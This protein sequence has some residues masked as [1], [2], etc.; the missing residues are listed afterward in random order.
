MS[1]ITPC[2]F[3]VLLLGSNESTSLEVCR[4]L[5]RAGH[6]VTILRIT[7]QKTAADHSRFCKESLYLGSPDAGISEYLSKLRDLLKLRRFDYLIPIDSLGCELTYFDYQAI[8]SLIS[9]VG[10]NPDSYAG[11][12]NRFEAL[13]LAESVGLVKPKTVLIKQGD[14]LNNQQLPCIVRPV[15]SVAIIDDEPQ[16]FS[17]RKVNSAEQLDAK[18]R[19][20]L[21]RSDVLLQEPV[22]GHVV[23]INFCAVNGKVLAASATLQL[24]GPYSGGRSSYVKSEELTPEILTIVQAIAHKLN[25]TGFMVIE[26]KR[27]NG[28]LYFM[29]MKSF[30][31]HSIALFSFSGVDFP[32]LMM[33]GLEHKLGADIVL[34][35][36]SRY[37]RQFRMDTAWLFKRLSKRSG[38]K[39]ILPWLGSF[40]RL[41]VGHERLDI[42]QFG[43]PLPTIHQFDGIFAWAKAKLDLRLF[44]LLSASA[45]AQPELK[46]INFKSTLLIVCKGNI[47]RSMVAEQ[48]LKARGFTNVRSAGLL[49][50]SSRKP[51]KEAEAFIAERLGINTTNLRSQSVAR[52]LREMA[53]EIELVL[54]FERSQVAELVWRFPN[55]KGKV[56][57]F[58]KLS[59]DANES[60]DIGDPH[61]AEPEVYLACFRKI[62]NIVDHLVSVVAGNGLSG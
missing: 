3:N 23:E 14:S 17:T 6:H 19:D 52:A 58:S 13:A 50:M 31:S 7:A 28:E 34:P 49:G 24:H 60:P 15:F 57:L 40:W 48:L 42:E 33:A 27:E 32:K 11:V 45:T 51:S 53:S 9:V 18:L 44:S 41:L 55:L 36:C 4:S 22:A 10:P 1:G 46:S 61:G 5:G 20:D 12:H 47:N 26:C 56:F 35:T 38:L 62:E 30:P 8:S 37:L 59:G 21:P 25:W 39:L 54:C 43:D 2:I 16:F 29:D